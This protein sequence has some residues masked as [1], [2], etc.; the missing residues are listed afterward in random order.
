VD[1]TVL[2]HRTKSVPQSTRKAIAQ[3]QAAGIPCVVATGRQIMEMK[4]LPCAD[5]P[6]DGYITLNGQLILDKDQNILHG[7]PVTGEVKDFFLKLFEEHTLPILLVEKDKMYLNFV[8]ERVDRVQ[9]DISSEIPALGTYTG[10]DIYQVCIYL[11]EGDEVLLEPVADK[12]VMSRWYLGGVDTI[13]KGGGK[14]SGI[15]RYLQDKNI[16]PEEI[17]A[18]G[19]GDNDAQMLSFAGIGVAMGNGWDSAKAAADYVTED[20]DADGV[21]LALK[22][23]GLVE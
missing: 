13:A 17:I 12:C 10:D 3:L 18:F 19:D 22:H 2:S 7:V 11:A 4:K 8:D 15:L 20:I 9:K 1:G 16:L 23:F 14:V 5:I 6:F 21:Y